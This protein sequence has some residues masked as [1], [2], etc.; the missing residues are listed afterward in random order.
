MTNTALDNAHTLLYTHT[1]FCCDTNVYIKC[2]FARA[3]KS[4][5]LQPLAL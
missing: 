3:L 2:G 1:M 5:L 4:T